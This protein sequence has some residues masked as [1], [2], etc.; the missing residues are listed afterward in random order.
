[1]VQA[2]QAVVV[3]SI[4]VEVVVEIPALLPAWTAVEAVLVIFSAMVQQ[5][6]LVVV[7]AVEHAEPLALAVVEVAGTQPHQPVQAVLVVAV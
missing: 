5:V 2:A 6:V 4:P 1:M 7:V 3:M